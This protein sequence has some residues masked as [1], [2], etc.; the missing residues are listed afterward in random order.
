MDSEFGAGVEVGYGLIKRVINDRVKKRR[1]HPPEFKAMVG[2][3]ALGGMKT[4]HPIAQRHGAHPI[5]VDPW[6]REIQVQAKSLF[7]DKRGPQPVSAESAPNQLYL[8]FAARGGMS[9]AVNFETGF[10]IYPASAW[11]RHAEKGCEELKAL[12]PSDIV[13]R[14]RA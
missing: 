1:V 5:Q 3:E 10:E 9:H 12:W 8:R 2:M 14:C 13:Q 11:R 4:I 6:K 7:E